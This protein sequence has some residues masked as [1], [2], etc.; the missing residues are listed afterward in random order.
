MGPFSA[1]GLD[2]PSVRAWGSLR[3]PY[4]ARVLV[5]SPTEVEALLDLDALVDA[6]AAALADLSAG[7]VSMPPRVAAMSESGLLGVMR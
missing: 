4:R 6:L 1:V 2:A 5:L 7:R 3:T